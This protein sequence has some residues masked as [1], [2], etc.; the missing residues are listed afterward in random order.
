MR[1]AV[2]NALAMS[3]LEDAKDRALVGYSFAISSWYVPPVTPPITMRYRDNEYNEL[4][5]MMMTITR[6]LYLHFVGVGHV[7]L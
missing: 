5:H 7:H 1:A 3:A 2:D 4:Q 6:S